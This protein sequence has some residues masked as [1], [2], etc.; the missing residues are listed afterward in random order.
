[1]YYVH[2]CTYILQL[3]VRT[4]HIPSVGIYGIHNDPVRGMIFRYITQLDV[5]RVIFFSFSNITAYRVHL[6][7][8]TRIVHVYSVVSFAVLFSSSPSYTYIFLKLVNTNDFENYS[9]NFSLQQETS[10][11]RQWF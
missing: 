6:S 4:L 1:M 7:I 11:P 3:A 9:S 5:S 2:T 8:L 10:F